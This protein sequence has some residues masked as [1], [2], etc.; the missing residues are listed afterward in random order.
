MSG[1]QIQGFITDCTIALKSS[2]HPED[3]FPIQKIASEG[4]HGK[5]LPE[6]ESCLS[7]MGSIASSACRKCLLKDRK[8]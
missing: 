7:Y 3:A 2:G 6:D 8:P 5:C 4:V 1:F